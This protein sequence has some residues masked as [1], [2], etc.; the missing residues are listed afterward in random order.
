[1]GKKLH[2]CTARRYFFLN[3]NLEK[4]EIEKNVVTITVEVCRLNKIAIVLK[5][6]YTENSGK[7]VQIELFNDGTWSKKKRKRGKLL[8]FLTILWSFHDLFLTIFLVFL[9]L[10][11]NF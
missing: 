8:F 9:F 10:K 1:M 11:N 2:S 4:R 6:W 3:L 5:W 7:A